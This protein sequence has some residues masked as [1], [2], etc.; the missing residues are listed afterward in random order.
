MSGGGLTEAELR[1][2]R[3]R[4]GGPVRSAMGSDLVLLSIQVL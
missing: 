3:V 1:A 2:T 4:V